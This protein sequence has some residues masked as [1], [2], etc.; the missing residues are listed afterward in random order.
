[1]TGD[2][3]GPELGPVGSSRLVGLGLIA[4]GFV[5]FGLVYLLWRYAPAAMPAPPGMP[6]PLLPLLSPLNC[7]VPLAAILAALLVL[8]GLQ[9]LLNPD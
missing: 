3:R 2:D 6:A 1:M 9:R 4:L 8:L 5:G 7:V